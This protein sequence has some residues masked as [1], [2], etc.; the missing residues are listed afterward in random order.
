MKMKVMVSLVALVIALALGLTACT[1]S[2]SD[3]QLAS[4]VQTKIGNDGHIQRKQITVQVQSGVITLSGSVN[5]EMERAMAA[6][7]AVLVSGVKTVVNNLQVNTPQVA[8]EAAPPPEPVRAKPSAAHRRR[9]PVA[10][11]QVYSDAPAAA[12]AP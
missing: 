7:D 4:E 6:N 10:R 1:R 11:P 8:Q 9:E 12:P 5:N 3:A 2:V